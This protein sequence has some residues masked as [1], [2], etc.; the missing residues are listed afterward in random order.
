MDGRMPITLN[1]A[2]IRMHYFVRVPNVGDLV[3][4]AL[5]A[6]IAGK[7]TVRSR[8][9]PHLLASGSIL[10]LAQPD[11]VI[12]GA[13]VM[14]PSFGIGASSAEN[15]F[16]VRGERSLVTL[17]EN[18]LDAKPAALGDPGFLAPSLL[19]IKRAT[20][21][22]FELGLVPHYTDRNDPEIR[23]LAI[24]SEVRLLDVRDD[25]R[26]FLHD[27]SE[28][29]AVAS[30]SLHG[31]IFAEALGIPN[32][33]F[34]AGND[35]EGGCF[36]FEDWFTTTALPQQRP[37]QL[38]AETKWNELAARAE[39]HDC[40]IDP[41]ALVEAFPEERLGQLSEPR[42]R[43]VPAAVCRAAPVPVFLISFNRGPFL[44][45]SVNAI[46]R[47][48]TPTSIVVHDNGSDDAE[49]IDVLRG[50]EAEG[51]V[52]NRRGRIH[53][54]DELNGVDETVQEFFRDWAEPTNYVVSDG[55]IDVGEADPR[56][57]DVYADFLARYRN[58]ACIGP[59]L[60]IDD[61]D[62]TYPLYGRVINRHVEQFWQHVPQSDVV[63]GFGVVW[64]Q[65]AKIDTTFALHRAGEPFKRLKD[66][67]RTYRPLEARH[68]D[69]YL[70]RISG[71]FAETASPR[72]S[73]WGTQRA[74]DAHGQEALRFRRF[75]AIEER[76]DLL[77]IIQKEL[78]E[79]PL[80]SKGTARG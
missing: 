37:V 35:I 28:C 25:P 71:R 17:R 44:R 23:R 61:I 70:E 41:Q 57:L 79:I 21:P 12:W 26:R 9:G 39:L 55:D 73:H 27:M 2:P 78:S 4:P 34:T 45:R 3:N 50:L 32:V 18:G 49:T 11:S 64:F 56:L 16:A 65:P 74:V 22:L 80:G 47:L 77:T 30:S 6:A 58:I 13:G 1:V 15:I 68:L 51:V 24:P 48:G 5:V 52:V 36:K 43:L 33:W 7:Q 63:P 67:L 42:R 46:R 59:M 10:A 53:T 40:R 38:D 19:G 60:R 29:A 62:P 54:A 66:G 69:W 31:L 14:H 8:S 75:Y 72:I 20:R 76:D